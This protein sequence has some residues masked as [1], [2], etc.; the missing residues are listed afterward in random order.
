MRRTRNAIVN[1][2][3]HELHYRYYSYSY[4]YHHQHLMIVICV[5]IGEEAN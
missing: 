4:Y 2:I 3:H 1:E 5:N